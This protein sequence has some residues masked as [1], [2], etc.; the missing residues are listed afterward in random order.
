MLIAAAVGDLK[1]QLRGTLS[2][3]L[4]LNTTSRL[5]CGTG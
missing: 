4:T 5:E 1:R 3:P 2:P